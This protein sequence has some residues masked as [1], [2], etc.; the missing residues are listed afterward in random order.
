MPQPTTCTYCDRSAKAATTRRVGVAR[1]SMY[2]DP[3]KP[4][5]RDRSRVEVVRWCLVEHRP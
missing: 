2:S 5:D 1:A 4:A 3:E